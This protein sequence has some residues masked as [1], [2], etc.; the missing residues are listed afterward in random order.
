MDR[1]ALHHAAGRRDGGHY[2]ALLTDAGAKTDVVDIVCKTFCVLCWPK[3]K[4]NNHVCLPFRQQLSRAKQ[5]PIHSC[6][7]WVA[8]W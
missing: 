2:Y 3:L 7:A 1:T 5:H 8:Q 6:P 4:K